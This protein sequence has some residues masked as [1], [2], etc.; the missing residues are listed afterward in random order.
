MI[1]I[2]K[3]LSSRIIIKYNSNPY[4]KYNDKEQWIRITDGCPHNCPFCYCPTEIKTFKIPEIIRNE[5]KVMD[6]NILANSNYLK[7]F[8]KLRNI[9]NNNRVVYYDFVCGFDYRY[10]NKKVAKE[11]KKLRVKK[12]RLAWDWYYKDQLKLKKVIDLFKKNKYQGKEIQI[13]MI[14]NW[15]IPYS[16]CCKKL[17]MLKFWGVEVADCYY[18]NQT[19]PNI[20]PIYWNDKQIKEFR[21]KCR[22]HNRTVRLSI[23]P[24]VLAE[25]NGG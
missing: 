12:I 5:V 1:E 22:R 13:F 17:D 2:Q 6:M 7:I 15:K 24:D 14:C 10:I 25:N 23:D 4:N 11:I 21:R 19:S 9:K 18:D 16:E 3:R 20:I 8:N